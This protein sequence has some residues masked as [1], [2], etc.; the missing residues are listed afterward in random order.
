MSDRPDRTCAGFPD[1]HASKR[2]D[3]YRLGSIWF[4]SN[5]LPCYVTIKE[6]IAAIVDRPTGGKVENAAAG[7]CISRA[8]QAGNFAA[9]VGQE[10]PSPKSNIVLVRKVNALVR[11]Y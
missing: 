1:V 4:A 2:I 5:F 9:F 10:G 7:S 11:C 3:E 6:Q 8:D